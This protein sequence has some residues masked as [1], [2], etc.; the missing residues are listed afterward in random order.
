MPCRKGRKPVREAYAPARAA[1]TNIAG[2]NSDPAT[3]E[4]MK[5]LYEKYVKE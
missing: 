2:A 4:T 3:V 1:M 5:T